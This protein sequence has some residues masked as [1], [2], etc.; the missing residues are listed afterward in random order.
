MKAE[1]ICTRPD[2]EAIRARGVIDHPFFTACALDIG[3]LSHRRN[4][5]VAHGGFD[6]DPESKW[7]EC[8]GENPAVCH[9]QADLT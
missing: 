2:S 8:L 5:R 3:V 6:G 7:T 9:P 4:S 1:A